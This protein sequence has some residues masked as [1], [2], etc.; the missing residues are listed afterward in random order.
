NGGIMTSAEAQRL[1]VQTLLS[2]PAAGVT[3]AQT[4]G[5]YLNVSD[6][7]TMDMGGTSTDL[8]LIQV[9]RST[10]TAQAEVGDFPLFLPVTAI[11]AMGAG[12]G[13]IIWL[14]GSVL[15]VG[16][17][18]AGSKPGPA[19]YASGGTQ[20]TL[21]DAYLLCGYISPHGLLGGRVP[22]SRELAVQAL[23]PISRHAH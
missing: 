10:V 21:T 20:P 17:K 22:L 9:G 1:P 19:C 18:S 11:E 23:A 5:D 7:L 2:G 14:D 3:G 6:I 15:K 16:P 4:L 8:S 13:S 12:G